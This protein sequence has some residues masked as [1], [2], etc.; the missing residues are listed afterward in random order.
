MHNPPNYTKHLETS[1][2]IREN[3][4]TKT[5]TQPDSTLVESPEKTISKGTCY[6]DSLI[7][8]TVTYIHQTL[9]Y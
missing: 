2:K 1:G 4:L 5:D 3:Y 8:E 6:T 9:N 7:Q